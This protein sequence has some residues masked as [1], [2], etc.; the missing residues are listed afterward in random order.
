MADVTIDEKELAALRLA[1]AFVA[2]H[3]DQIYY[4]NQF[5]TDIAKQQTPNATAEAFLEVREGEIKLNKALD[6]VL[7]ALGNVGLLD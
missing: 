4:L 2:E 6:N 7:D 3:E 1:A 5:A